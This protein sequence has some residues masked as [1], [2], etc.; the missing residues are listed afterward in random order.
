MKSQ[1]WMAALIAAGLCAGAVAFAHDYTVSSV[2]G[3][4]T[5]MGK[6]GWKPLTPGTVLSESSQVNVGLNSRLVISDG[7]EEIVIPQMKRGELGKLTGKDSEADSPA[8]SRHEVAAE[9]TGSRRAVQTAASRADDMDDEDD[10]E[11]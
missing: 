2:T 1:K 9:A 6:G 3:K 8:S 4:V 11:D 10:W 7:G 5:V